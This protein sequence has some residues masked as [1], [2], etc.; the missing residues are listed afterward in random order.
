[1]K[2]DHIAIKVPDIHTASEWYCD[3]LGSK[4]VFETNFYK[5]LQLDNTII[6][7][8]DE[9]CYK[10]NHIAVL[11]EKIDDF[12]ENGEI[13]QHRDGTTGCYLMD[14]YG[15]CVEFI[16]YGQNSGDNPQIE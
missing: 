1:M 10:H 3:K 2:I 7:I 12:P 14:P 8:V 5:R 16:Y 4:V 6:A 13:I 11:V 9:K 15:N